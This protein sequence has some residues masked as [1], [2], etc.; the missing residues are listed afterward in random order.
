VQ[1][2]VA[3]RHPEVGPAAILATLDQSGADQQ[4]HVLGD[5]GLVGSDEVGQLADAHLLPF[6]GV[7]HL[8]ATRV[9]R[10]LGDSGLGFIL[11]GGQRFNGIMVI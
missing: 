6:E 4:I 3:I 10:G 2:S 1:G 11:L 7:Q 8:E 5:G 9:G